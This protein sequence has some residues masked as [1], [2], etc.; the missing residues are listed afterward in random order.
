M[1]SK[2][3]MLLIDSS[4]AVLRVGLCCGGVLYSRVHDSS[5]KHGTVVLNLIKELCV[6]AGVDFRDFTHLC[7]NRGPGSFT[8]LRLALSVIQA[9]ALSS[10]A[11]VVSLSSLELLACQAHRSFSYERVI[12]LIDARMQQVY[13]ATYDVS[14]TNS[15]LEGEEKIMPLAELSKLSKGSSI[16]GISML[17]F[18]D[19]LPASLRQDATLDLAIELEVMALV[20]QRH[21]EQG[22]AISIEQA[23]PVYLYNYVASG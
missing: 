13:T 5:P 17:G 10:S 22:K 6:E 4:T 20:A 3:N 9:L 23:Q 14:V 21:I 1:L 12:C 19:F 11:K 7:W 16:V 8:G 18:K 15:V 2:S